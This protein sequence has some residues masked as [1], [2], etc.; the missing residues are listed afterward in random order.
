M[1]SV[2]EKLLISSTIDSSE[3]DYFVW[4]A[5]LGEPQL[6]EGLMCYFDGMTVAF[7]GIP[8]K[9]GKSNNQLRERINGVLQWW[10]KKPEVMFINYFGPERFEPQSAPSFDQ[11]YIEGPEEYDLDLFINL[12]ST[13]NPA[14]ARKMRQ[15]L[16][17]AERNGIIVQARKQEYLTA[18]QLRLM[19][20]LVQEK[21]MGIS[22]VSYLV[23]SATLLRHDCSLIFEARL[24]G[25]LV[26]IGIAHQYFPRRPFF[27]S[28]AFSSFPAGVSDAVYSSIISHY[29]SDGAEQLG[30][31]YVATRGQYEYKKKWGGEAVNPPCWQI[32]WRRRG[33]TIPFRESLHWGWRITADKW[34]LM[35]ADKTNGN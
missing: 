12:K 8:V 23:N 24:N 28:A 13:P 2:E 18:E 14:A 27:I 31:G 20:V 22:D 17:R 15:D 1:L 32:I 30:L 9:D 10:V 3:H 21:D 33:A 26:G 6:I 25:N 29:K 16:K 35:G 11:V 34:D 5:L 4:S 7:A 19:S